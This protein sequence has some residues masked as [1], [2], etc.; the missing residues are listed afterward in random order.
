MRRTA[1]KHR[2][3]VVF[4]GL[5]DEYE[6]EGTDRSHMSLPEGVNRLIEAVTEVNR[7]TVVVLM[8]GSP[9]ECPWADRAAAILYMGLPGQEGGLACAR[10]LCGLASPGGRLAETW[11]M[12]YADVPSASLYTRTRDALY[13]RGSMWATAIT[14]RPGCR[15][16][17]PLATA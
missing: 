7:N 14:P 2:Y 1:A 12:R 9:V 17:G 4:A 11:P 5:P 8:C 13:A 10:L 15:C 3:A 16:A 6:S